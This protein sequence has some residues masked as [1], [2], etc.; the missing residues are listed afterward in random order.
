MKDLTGKVVFVTG[1]ASGIGLGIYRAAVNAGMKVMMADI[2]A[3]VL[4]QAHG[5]LTHGLQKSADV[6]KIVCDVSDRNSVG[7]AAQATI[8]RFGKVHLLC[9]NAGVSSGGM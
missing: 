2:E 1:A 4:E 3:P 7:K 6:E 9:N 8:E 5:L